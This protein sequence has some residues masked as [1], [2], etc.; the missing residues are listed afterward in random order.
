M[1]R[2]LPRVKHMP[3][4]QHEDDVFLLRHKGHAS[5]RPINSTDDIGLG[6]KS[7][8]YCRWQVCELSLTIRPLQPDLLAK[9][10]VRVDLAL[11]IGY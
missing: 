5:L 4:N 10:W 2:C 11:A 1:L 9:F 6:R 7:A 8:T 3:A